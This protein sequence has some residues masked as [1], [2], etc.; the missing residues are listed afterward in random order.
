MSGLH[1]QDR[2]CLG[3]PDDV[4]DGYAEVARAAVH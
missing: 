4:E 2:L 3:K 1:E